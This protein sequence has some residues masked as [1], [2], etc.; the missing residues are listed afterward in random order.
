MYEDVTSESVKAGENIVREA[1]DN[2]PL[3]ADERHSVIE[4]LVDISECSSITILKQN[5]EKPSIWD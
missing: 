3:F 5:Q 2:L 4:Y 1:I